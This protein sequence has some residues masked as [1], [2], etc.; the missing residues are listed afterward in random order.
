MQETSFL[1]LRSV[2]PACLA[3]GDPLESPV[4]VC[5]VIPQDSFEIKPEVIIGTS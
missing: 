5:G 3:V 1:I 4:S 2:S